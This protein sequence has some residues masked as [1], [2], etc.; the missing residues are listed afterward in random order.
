MLRTLLLGDR[1]LWPVILWRLCFRCGRRSN[2]ETILSEAWF[3]KKIGLCGA[4]P[5]AFRCL[6]ST[7]PRGLFSLTSKASDV[8]FLVRSAIKPETVWL[9]GWRFKEI[10]P[11]GSS[12]RCFR[13]AG[14]L[15]R[16]IPRMVFPCAVFVPCDWDQRLRWKHL[17]RKLLS[18]GDRSLRRIDKDRSPCPSALPG[19]CL[20]CGVSLCHATCLAGGLPGKLWWLLCLSE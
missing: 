19:Y 7:P 5:D 8:L 9:Q 15:C 14:L 12:S 11:C 6:L 10:G 1:S 16:F 13:L 17:A 3:V 2:P 20:L 18:E 4:F